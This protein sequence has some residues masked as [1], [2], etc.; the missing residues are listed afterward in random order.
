VFIIRKKNGDIIAI[1]SRQKDAI[2]MADAAKVDKEDYIVQESHDSV[3]L[4]EIY[5]SYYKTRS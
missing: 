2:G 3:E 5:R 1:A 4:R